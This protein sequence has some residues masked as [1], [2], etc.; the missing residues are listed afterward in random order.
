MHNIARPPAEKRVK[1]IFAPKGKA[2]IAAILVTGKA[3]PKVPAPR[4]LAHIA[5]ESTDVSDLRRRHSPG[6]FGKHRVLMP[7]DIVAT[8]CVERDETTDIH[9]CIGTLHLIETFD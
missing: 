8:Q 5:G 6:G 1:L 7:N 3:V 9:A 4:T 2:G